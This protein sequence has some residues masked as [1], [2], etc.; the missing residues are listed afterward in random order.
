MS[1]KEKWRIHKLVNEI[2]KD[3]GIDYFTPPQ[4]VREPRF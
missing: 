1:F 2:W 3:K 4:A